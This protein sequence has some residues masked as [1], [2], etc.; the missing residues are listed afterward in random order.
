MRPLCQTLEAVTEQTLAT[1]AVAD[2]IWA[3]LEPTR[4]RRE[5]H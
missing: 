2:T 1:P 3:E 5:W 4:N